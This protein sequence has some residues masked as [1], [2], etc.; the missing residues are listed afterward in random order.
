MH[1][2]MDKWLSEG[3]PSASPSPN[4]TLSPPAGHSVRGY[5]TVYNYE[6]I[7]LPPSGEEREGRD[8]GS[9]TGRCH[10]PHLTAPH[11]AV[12]SA[13]L[14]L[15]PNTMAA[16][17]AGGSHHRPQPVPHS[18]LGLQRGQAIHKCR[19]SSRDD[20]R[21]LLS[22]L[23]W[24]PHLQAQRLCPHQP[25]T[26]LSTP[27]PGEHPRTSLAH[28]PGT[29]PT[30]PYPA[31]QL[32]GRPLASGSCSKAAARLFPC[33]GQ[34]SPQPPSRTRAPRPGAGREG[35]QDHLAGWW[36][37]LALRG[38]LPMPLLPTHPQ[39]APR[40]VGPQPT[41]RPRGAPSLGCPLHRPAAACLGPVD[42]QARL[43]GGRGNTGLAGTE[44]RPVCIPASG[45]ST[46]GWQE[47]RQ[48]AQGP[49]CRNHATLNTCTA[50]APH[51]H[52]LPGPARGPDAQQT[53]A[54][55]PK[56]SAV[57]KGPR[58]Q[59]RALGPSQHAAPAGT[60]LPQATSNHV[61]QSSLAEILPPQ[62]ALPGHPLS[63]APTPC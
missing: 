44:S 10:S 8:C 25:L 20:T 6:L 30:G 26:P 56:S 28:G 49:V 43:L 1:G 2:G 55:S 57:R 24:L 16:L 46:P 23:A 41:P 21:H 62:G 32:P 54:R 5:H 13:F 38:E 34:P 36:E 52:L 42:P 4:R 14:P 9:P 48:E 12:P 27:R 45:L 63:V 40:S 35:T 50:G 59:D 18:A 15:P 17:P 29:L 47:G 19:C 39:R 61:R 53:R 33:L 58:R 60:L 37:S 7:H 31:L 22:H 3:K 11:P 51:T